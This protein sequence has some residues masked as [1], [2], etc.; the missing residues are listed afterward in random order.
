MNDVCLKGFNIMPSAPAWKQHTNVIDALK[1]RATS[2]DLDAKLKVALGASYSGPLAFQIKMELQR[3]DKISK[4]PIRVHEIIDK[5]NTEN[6]LRGRV[7][8]PE[9]SWYR[10]QMKIGSAT[11]CGCLKLPGTANN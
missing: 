2:K 7:R 11:E 4:R 1:Y 10:K 5:I 8:V 9:S 6:R 3:Q